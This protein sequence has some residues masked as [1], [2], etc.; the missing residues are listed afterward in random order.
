MARAQA[1]EPISSHICNPLDMNVSEAWEAHFV[2]MLE[3]IVVPS[4]LRAAG[5]AQSVYL[6][7]GSARM[8]RRIT[9]W[10]AQ[11]IGSISRLCIVAAHI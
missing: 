10:F 2:V 7:H 6:V 11:P 5:G 4:G 9:Q 8:R 3:E 1:L